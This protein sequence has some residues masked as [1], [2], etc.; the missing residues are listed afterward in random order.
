[1]ISTGESIIKLIQDYR[2]EDAGLHSAYITDEGTIRLLFDIPRNYNGWP[3]SR[4]EE[5]EARHVGTLRWIE[6]EPIRR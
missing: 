5:E 1:M 6:L 2:L 4:E 3:M